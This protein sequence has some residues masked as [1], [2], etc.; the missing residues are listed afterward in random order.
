M[1]DSTQQDAAEPAV[2]S[3]A[4]VFILGSMR[5]GSTMLRLILDSHENISIGAETGFM[6]AVAATKAVPGWTYGKDWYRRIAWTEDEIDAR[7]REFYGG[8]FQ[9]YAASNGKRRWGDKTPF[10]TAHVAQ[11]ARVFPD[12]VFV[13][14]VRHPGAVA[15]SL[16]NNFH[17]TFDAA[18]SY[19][20]AT[21]LEVVREGTKLGPRFVALRY[22]DLVVEREPVLRELVRWL[23]EPWSPSLLQHERVQRD[24][25]TPRAT[26]GSTSTRDPIDVKRASNWSRELKPENESVLKE[27]GDLAA[28]FGYDALGAGDRLPL[29]CGAGRQWLPDGTDL[30]ARR[31]EWAGR[32]DFEQ[33][34]PVVDVD[35]DA[36]ELATR[37]DRV[38]RTLARVRSR[39]AVRISDAI[40]TVQHGR[41]AR[42]VRA[43][44]ARLRGRN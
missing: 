38:E 9:R 22:E 3:A 14:I 5:S 27:V 7:L 34:R 30:L 44:Y 33:R 12:S 17:Y 4:P 24:R 6:G 40:R 39:K 32:V 20:A 15:V 11:M 2:A 36:V 18:V 37:L 16:Q 8:M 43:A 23:G 19:W 35:A 1:S 25:G 10:H 29:A 31:S 42:D 28:F 13:G 41:S 26:D 21:N